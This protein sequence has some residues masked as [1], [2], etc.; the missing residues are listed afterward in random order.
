M[1]NSR[2][3][4]VVSASPLGRWLVRVATAATLT[5]SGG[6]WAQ[7]PASAAPSLR[8]DVEG[9]V[10]SLLPTV[11]RRQVV[12]TS[13]GSLNVWLLSD[14]DYEKSVEAVRKALSARKVLRA[15]L[16]IERWSYLESDR[17]WLI[18]VAGDERPWRLRLSRHLAGS[19]VEVQDVGEATDAPRWSPPLRPLFVPLLHGAASR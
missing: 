7:V 16:R 5:A 14:L 9:A 4:T 8:G 11:V 12:R 17:S 2:D 3:S 10:A 18:D 6:A 1:T 13:D 15:N 19:L